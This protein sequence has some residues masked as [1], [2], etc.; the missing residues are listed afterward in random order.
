M[1]IKI[2]NP[3]E[4][5]VLFLCMVIERR[6]RKVDVIL[7]VNQPGH[8]SRLLIVPLIVQRDL[9]LASSSNVLTGLGNFLKVNAGKLHVFL[10]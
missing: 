3:L 4:L 9:L 7:E 2:P 8:P 6:L 5:G 1:L 10:F